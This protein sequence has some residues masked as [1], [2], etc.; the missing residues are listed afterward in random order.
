MSKGLVSYELVRHKDSEHQ[1]FFSE[2]K[3]DQICSALR[4]FVLVAED[5][6]DSWAEEIGFGED[7]T[8]QTLLLSLTPNTGTSCLLE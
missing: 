2:E 5:G 6:K 7:T 4:N 8:L 1:D 3:L